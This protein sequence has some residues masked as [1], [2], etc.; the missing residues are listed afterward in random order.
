MV[1]FVFGGNSS[2]L[3]MP[4]HRIDLP[5]KS[6]RQLGDI[7]EEVPLLGNFQKIGYNIFIMTIIAIITLQF[8]L[9]LLLRNLQLLLIQEAVLCQY[10][11][12]GMI[13]N[14]SFFHISI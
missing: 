11:V 7:L 12:Q 9:E 8:I 14:I 6:M 2:L 3:V 10:H 5:V 4:L 13:I 1:M